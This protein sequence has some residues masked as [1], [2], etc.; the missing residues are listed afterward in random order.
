MPV[1]RF[2]LEQGG[3]FYPRPDLSEGNALI[4]DFRYERYIDPNSS[5]RRVNSLSSST[6]SAL[7]SGLVAVTSSP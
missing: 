3:V 1:T 5:S 6:I 7:P 4:S 2:P